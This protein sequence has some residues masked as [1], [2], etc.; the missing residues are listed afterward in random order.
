MRFSS[1]RATFLLFFALIAVSWEHLFY[2]GG[3]VVGGA[4]RGVREEGGERFAGTAACARDGLW[5]GGWGSLGEVGGAVAGGQ[6]AWRAGGGRAEGVVESGGLV[7]R[8]LAVVWV[9]WWSRRGGTGGAR[10]SCAEGR[11]RVVRRSDGRR[12][13]ACGWWDGWAIIMSYDVLLFD[14][15]RWLVLFLIPYYFFRKSMLI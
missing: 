13:V 11:C 7:W 10:G 6:V 9:V 8:G 4:L 5:W 12:L 14:L 2:W 1:C 3:G 15:R